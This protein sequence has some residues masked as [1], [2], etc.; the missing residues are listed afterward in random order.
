M[1]EELDKGNKKGL[2]SFIDYKCFQ[3]F[4]SVEQQSGNYSIHVLVA[5]S[6]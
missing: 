5:E 1:K 2:M 6:W 3:F 4:Y